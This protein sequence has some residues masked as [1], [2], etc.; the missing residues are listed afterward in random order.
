[1]KYGAVKAAALWTPGC[2]SVPAQHSP[3]DNP[4]ALLLKEVGGEGSRCRDAA[5]EWESQ[6][7]G[8][9]GAMP[10]GL[11]YRGDAPDPLSRNA[12]P[13]CD[14]CSGAN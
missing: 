4:L 2:Y 6:A 7:Q 13:A 11:E 9:V 3:G 10:V 1:M 5:F 8:G 14:C 12:A